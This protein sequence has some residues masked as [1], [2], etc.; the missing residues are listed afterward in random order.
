MRRLFF[1]AFLFSALPGLLAGETLSINQFGGLDQVND[2]L[3]VKIGMAQDSENVMTD[4][5]LGL[6]PRTG[7]VAFSTEASNGQWIFP[8]AN[9]S[10]YRITESSGTLKALLNGSNFT[11]TL[12]TIN[13][14]VRTA[15]AALGDRFYW[16]SADGLKYWDTSVVV[17]SS[18]TLNFTSMAVYKG[19]LC[20]I[21][22]TG[23]ERTI[24][25]S[26]Y[27]DGSNFTLAVDPVDTDPARIAVQG[28]LDE[29]LTGLFSSFKDKLI[30]MKAN[31]FG[32]IAGSRRSNFISQVFN[33]SVG[34][35]YPESF[36]D[37]DGKLRFLGSKR[38]I[39][40]FDG[41]NIKPISLDIETT[42][43]NNLTQ[44][45]ANSRSFSQTSQ[46]DWS[47]GFSRVGIDTDNAPGDVW[48]KP[49]STVT[50]LGDTFNDND[51]TSNPA[52]TVVSGSAVVISG[53]LRAETANGVCGPSVD[54]AASLAIESNM[55]TGTWHILGAPGPSSDG[56]IWNAG[57][58][59]P[60]FR[61]NF[62][63][64]QAVGYPGYAIKFTG[65]GGG[66]TRIQLVRRDE[67]GDDTGDKVLLSSSAAGE[68][69]SVKVS[70]FSSGTFVV[71]YICSAADGT[72]VA[73][74][75][76]NADSSYFNITW[77][78]M[79]QDFGP[80]IDQ[81]MASTPSSL[82]IYQSTYT[83]QTYSMGTEATAWGGFVA[84][85]VLDAGT[86]LT[87]AIYVDTDSNLDIDEQTSFVSSQAIVSGNVPT[88]QI[89]S[90][91]TIAAF[92]DRS[93]HTADAALT[94]FT[95]SWTE[96]SNLPAPS[97]YYKQRYELGVAVSSNVN[98]TVLVYD[99]NN[100]WQKWKG[101]NRNSAVV[102]NGLSYF[103]NSTGIYQ[104]D[105]GNSDAGAAITSFYKTKRFV[106]S[107]VNYVNYF[108]ELYLTAMNSAETMN[109]QY[110]VDGVN[111]PYTLANYVMNSQAGQQDVR[112]PFTATMLEQG[113]MI[114]FL[115]TV[116]GTSEWR[117]V[118]A[119]LNFT[120]E[121]IP[122]GN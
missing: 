53:T 114:E 51:Y 41:S 42:L 69:T 40:E 19:R 27:L 2:P 43:M 91:V 92:F 106:P 89:S 86:T 54:C 12:S 65:L 85:E 98:N 115:F 84:G 88:I 18:R 3:F 109:I 101:M 80:Q 32:G 24:Y 39:W 15:A 36:K 23:D 71:A 35:A 21:G 108:N 8:L 76:T 107:G 83:S 78:A 17:V 38:A 30:W 103:G 81:V 113:K 95:V 82:Y 34:S 48:F 50:L 9:G 63:A 100:Q 7:F 122:S 75:T 120:G 118:N 47:Q 93:T 49:L 87:Y 116:S 11:I 119:N 70:R 117:L 99:R 112:L 29:N 62:M 74:D 64:R 66:N 111:T 102:Y 57:T 61:Y 14:A 59:G 6:A 33:D 45:D 90:Y 52:W 46:Q 25:L 22:V 37:C 96:G 72:M 5:A 16:S 1:I 26:E 55:S 60:D 44:G 73:R 79:T 77:D 68:C 104:A 58:G 67:N 56:G 105:F 20:G 13:T 4:N 121:S 31:S 97:V 110:Y 94:N 10:S 28:N